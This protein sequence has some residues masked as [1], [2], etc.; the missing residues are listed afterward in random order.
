MDIKNKKTKINKENDKLNKN[1]INEMT[2]IYKI[3]DKFKIKI[4]K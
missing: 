2:I 4:L 3:E 1:T